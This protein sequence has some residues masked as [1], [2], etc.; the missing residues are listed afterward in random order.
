MGGRR[1]S[2]KGFAGLAVSVR[3]ARA[4]PLNLQLQKKHNIGKKPLC[5]WY[6]GFFHCEKIRD[7][8][9][10]KHI[11]EDFRR[12]VPGEAP[13]RGFGLGARTP[14]KPCSFVSFAP[15]LWPFSELQPFGLGART[16]AKPCSS[17]SLAPSFWSFSELQ[18]LGLGARTP[19]KPYFFVSLA[20]SF[21]P[22][23]ELQ[24]FGLC[25][26]VIKK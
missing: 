5:T 13:L 24:P 21:W 8:G 6:S 25:L 16:P 4:L 23:S 2:G 18:P 9:R 20:P 22:F 10:R 11:V 3:V 14:A 26:C 19:A 12:R 17:V 15:S 1:P 7:P